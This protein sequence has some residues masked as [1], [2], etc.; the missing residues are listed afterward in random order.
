M[1]L[2]ENF[3]EGIRSIKANLLRSMLT[4][5][6]VAIGIL[7]LV[8]ILTA[9]DGIQ[10][11][12]TDSLAELGVNKFDIS[13][14]SFRGGRQE[15]VVE[16]RYS[17]IT[18]KESLK[19]IKDYSYP[20]NVSLST[21]VSQ[22]AE[23]KKGSKKTD[24]NVQIT[25]ANEDYLILNGIDIEEGRNFS[26]LEIQYGSNVAI[27]G[28]T[29]KK[30]LYKESE[31][32]INDEIVIFGHKFR[33]IGVLEEK[34]QLEG[35]GSDNSIVIPVV[36]ASK[37]AGNRTLRYNISVGVDDP[38]AIDEAM[39]EATAIM[40]SIRRDPIGEENS[41]EISK[42]ET[43]SQQLGSITSKIR[44]G[45]IGIA[46]I[47]LLGASIAL[48]NIMLVSVTERTR[49]VGIR[50]ALGATP[51]KIRHQFIIEA[52]VVCLM[53]GIVGIILGIVAGNL[54]SV[55]VFKNF[56]IPWLWMI[57]GVTVCVVVGLISGYYPAYKASKVDPIESLRFE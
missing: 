51:T 15:G 16:K 17:H 32:P 21:M 43:L 33:V 8:G 24:P 35:G 22:V 26:L 45:G 27:L 52:I 34:G 56:V 41:F 25:G 18:F 23:I 37:I 12:V 20:A 13:S 3:R 46:F 14:K 10:A 30:K 19:F 28:P 50:K 36:A 38:S 9:I 5:A 42:S 29:V 57:I 54:F 53:G 40:R 7:S 6:I 55:L 1:N 4:A 39:G 44:L 11:S 31:S 2:Q 48:V 47:T 49:E